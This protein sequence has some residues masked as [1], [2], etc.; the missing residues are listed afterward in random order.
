M[1]DMKTYYALATTVYKFWRANGFTLAQACGLVAQADAESSLDPEAVGDHD[2][3][4][5]L[6]QWHGARATAILKGCGVDLTKLPPV[7]DQLKAAHW[8]LQHPESHALA[9]IKATKTAY[10]AGYAACRYWERPAST[11]QYAKRG[12]KAETWAVFFQKN[13]I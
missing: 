5:G 8:E 7:A 9:K 2:E 10:D 12:D 13:P 11:L 3:A 6:Q 4:F 1:S